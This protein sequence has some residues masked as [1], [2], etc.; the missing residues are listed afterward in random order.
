MSTSGLS[1]NSYFEFVR[2]VAF[3]RTGHEMDVVSS[4]NASLIDLT[5]TALLLPAPSHPFIQQPKTKK[6]INMK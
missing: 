1:V 6:L 4:A 5:L 2:G 3:Y